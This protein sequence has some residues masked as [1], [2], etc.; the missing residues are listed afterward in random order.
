[1]PLVAYD[2]ICL[3]ITIQHVDL[4]SAGLQGERKVEGGGAMRGNFKRK[5]G[6]SLLKGGR[7]E[8]KRWRERIAFE[9]GEGGGGGCF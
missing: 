4:I 2:Q 6:W 8:R 3:D 7:R 5:G 1:M 9:G